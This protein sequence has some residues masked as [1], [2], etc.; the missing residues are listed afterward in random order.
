MKI[1]IKVYF[2]EKELEVNL[3]DGLKQEDIEE[4]INKLLYDEATDAITK[5][6]EI[7]YWEEI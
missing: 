1:K 3:P 2:Q 5:D 6:I 4:E 7:D